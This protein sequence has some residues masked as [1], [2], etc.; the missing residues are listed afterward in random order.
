MP[1]SKAT[2]ESLHGAKGLQAD[3]VILLGC[4][5]RVRGFPSEFTDH[6]A[7]DIIRSHRDD[8]TEEERRLFY[9]GLT[10]CKKEI[11]LFTSKRM[12]SR[13]ITEIENYVTSHESPQ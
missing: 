11:F 4:V 8:K 12:K 10:R 6:E 13:F 1:R 5:E 9:V 3:R 2:F 7:L